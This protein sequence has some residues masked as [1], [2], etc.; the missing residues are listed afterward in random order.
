MGMDGK[1]LAVNGELVLPHTK[2]KDGDIV[3]VRTCAV[4]HILLRII[5]QV[6]F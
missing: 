5:Y 3:E 2:L 6:G 4:L 1:L